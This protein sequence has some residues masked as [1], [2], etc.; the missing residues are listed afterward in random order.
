MS[1]WTAVEYGKPDSVQLR[2]DDGVFGEV[3][4]EKAT[5]IL[6]APKLLE[7]LRGL[8]RDPEGSAARD[9]AWAAIAKA[10]GTSV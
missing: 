4:R 5:L 3:D 9:A 8:M 2:D 7:A 6:A 10:E 1:E